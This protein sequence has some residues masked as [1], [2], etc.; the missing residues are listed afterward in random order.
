MANVQPDENQQRE[1]LLKEIISRKNL[2]LRW[3][4]E[5]FAIAQV[6]GWITIIASFGSA[7]AAAA[8][9][10]SIAV[11]ITAAIPG[12]VILIDR[13]FAFVRR[14]KWHWLSYH[15]LLGLE[16]ELKYQGAQVSDISKR[17]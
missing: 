8:K 6:R 9:G 4:D 14:A 16:H 2:D 17:Y 1:S 11:A 10:P 13:N 3:G 15:K 12:T 5:N 7:I